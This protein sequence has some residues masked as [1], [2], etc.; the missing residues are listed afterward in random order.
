MNFRIKRNVGIWVFWILVFLFIFGAAIALYKRV[1]TD[2]VDAPLSEKEQSIS[3][4][5]DQMRRKEASL[6]RSEDWTL[7][8]SGDTDKVIEKYRNVKISGSAREAEQARILGI[9]GRVAKPRSEW[10]PNFNDVKAGELMRFLE[11]VMETGHK[12]GG[13]GAVAVRVLSEFVAQ[14]PEFNQRATAAIKTFYEVEERDSNKGESLLALGKFKTREGLNLVLKASKSDKIMIVQSA[15][16]SLSNMVEKKFWREEAFVGL[17]GVAQ[18]NTAMR[19]LA[20]KLLAYH[21][22]PQAAKWVPLLLTSKASP[23][24]VEA[25]AFA[26]GKLKLKQ[27]RGL[28]QKMD[29]RNNSYLMGIVGQALHDLEQ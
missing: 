27:F 18:S 8:E 3:E 17:R 1:D 10:P 15:V 11:E 20:V 5:Q 13:M 16:Y 7:A 12:P 2:K 6:Q 22:D 24:A 26:I 23:A 21:G 9:L 4:I 25:A 28:L 19:P 14:N 29:V